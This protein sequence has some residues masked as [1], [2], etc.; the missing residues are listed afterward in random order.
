MV[1]L[2]WDE[3]ETR[4][5]FIP[6]EMPIKEVLK[7]FRIN[8]KQLD[9]KSSLTPPWKNWQ[10]IKVNHRWKLTGCIQ[11][12]Q[13]PERR[14]ELDERNEREQ[15]WRRD[16]KELINRVTREKGRT[17]IATTVKVN[18]GG[19]YVIE[20]RV[21]VEENDHIITVLQ[22]ARLIPE[23]FKSGDSP[24]GKT[25]RRYGSTQNP[26]KSNTGKQTRY[27]RSHTTS[28]GKSSSERRN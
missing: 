12:P 21:G 1:C 19:K 23:V 3:E 24:R 25:V 5:K 7:G 16:N 2:N 10:T 11:I 26:E 20:Q 27:V 17:D 4:E 6:C 18:V 15:E 8:H 28:G 14:A 22:K 13:T 9:V